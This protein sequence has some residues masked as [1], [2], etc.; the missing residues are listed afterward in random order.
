[1]AGET[2]EFCGWLDTVDLWQEYAR[3]R[4]FLFAAEEDCG[5][6]ALEAQACG[7]PVIAYGKGGSLE[8]VVDFNGG[9]QEVATGLFFSEQSV[10]SVIAAIVAFER[11]EK[12][13]SPSRI[14]QRARSFDVSCFAEHIRG[15]VRR[16]VPEEMELEV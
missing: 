6:V 15:F 1:M 8:T 11:I 12:R 7:R 10:E 16:V 5:M 9:A 2:I 4:A 14:Q 13:F 3:C